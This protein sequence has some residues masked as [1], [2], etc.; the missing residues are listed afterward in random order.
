MYFIR[1]GIAQSA[2]L[3]DYELDDRGTGIRFLAGARIFLFTA[4]RPALRPTEPPG[5]K[6]AGT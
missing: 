2:K 5:G 3:L 6:A 1:T 4:L